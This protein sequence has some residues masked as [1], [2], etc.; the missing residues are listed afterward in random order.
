MEYSVTGRVQLNVLSSWQ[1]TSI[2]LDTRTGVLK[3][4]GRKVQIRGADVNHSR[5][6]TSI[7]T[8]G[9]EH[10][11]PQILTIVPVSRGSAWRAFSCALTL[12]ALS[13]PG[14]RILRQLGD[15]GSG[16]V[17]EATV[18]AREQT[19][20]AGLT[21]VAIKLVPRSH[22][23]DCTAE[24]QM[25]QVGPKNSRV[26]YPLRVFYTRSHLV[27]VMELLQGGSLLE[28]VAKEAVDLS[29]VQS[30]ARELLEAV[31]VLHKMGVAHRDIKLENAL[32][33]S[34]GSVRLCDL[35]MAGLV[36]R[37]GF[38]GAVGTVYTQ[39]PE[40]G[41]DRYGLPA[42][43][44]SVGV[45]LL[46]LILRAVP[47]SPTNRDAVFAKMRRFSAQG[48]DLLA[49]IMGKKR[50]SALPPSLLDLLR[51]LLAFDPEHRLNVKQ[52][53]EHQFMTETLETVTVLPD[54]RPVSIGALCDVK[55][56]LRRLV[57]Q[58]REGMER[59]DEEEKSVEVY[60][61]DDAP[62]LQMLSI[63]ALIDIKV[64]LR[65]LVQNMRERRRE[66]MAQA[67]AVRQQENAR[68]QTRRVA[69]KWVNRIMRSPFYRLAGTCRQSKRARNGST[70]PCS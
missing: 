67:L 21:R 31:E 61:E 3:L 4:S 18:D 15:G 26:V 57:A 42:D 66:E 50:R 47:F 37:K 8:H 55:V 62:E 48:G 63:G 16:R 35:G 1:K 32:L 10:R 14:Y 33:D 70:L 54:P 46:V 39:A 64:R 44:W 51:G 22:S 13:P 36:P 25:S 49:A 7:V 43:M 38:C 59:G 2:T 24:V 19:N 34:D 60:S 58:M 20:V 27:L 30:I 52:A 53:L 45:V 68:S 6:G 56:R 41:V 40:V 9:G 69:G 5:R 29:R 23:D 65:R 17:Y 11:R 12:A 28:L